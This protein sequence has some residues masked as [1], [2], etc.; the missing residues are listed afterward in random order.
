MSLTALCKGCCQVNCTAIFTGVFSLFFLLYDEGAPFRSTQFDI[1]FTVALWFGGTAMGRQL[2]SI[3]KFTKDATKDKHEESA[4]H[5]LMQT[6][7][8]NNWPVHTILQY[9]N[10]VFNIYAWILAI[11]YWNSGGAQEVGGFDEVFT[12]FTI[13]FLGSLLL[14]CG[15]CALLQIELDVRCGKQTVTC[16]WRIE[17]K[18]GFDYKKGTSDVLD[19][20]TMG[21]NPGK[22][23]GEVKLFKVGDSVNAYSWNGAAW[24]PNWE[25]TGRPY[26]GDGSTK[27]SGIRVLS[28]DS[29]QGV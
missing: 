1:V 7:G 23:Q 20:S 3:V 19:E 16:S 9:G 10:L 12:L 8:L 5:D 13:I 27:N 14:C 2:D 6:M 4:A 26:A 24:D 29:V 25:V 11:L 15:C 28:F 22:K 18:S 17:G 21:S